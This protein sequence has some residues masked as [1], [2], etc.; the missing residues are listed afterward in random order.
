MANIPK[1]LD[2]EHGSALIKVADKTNYRAV[3]FHLVNSYSEFQDIIVFGNSVG[4]WRNKLIAKSSVQVT[5]IFGM[6][7]QALRDKDAK[8][9]RFLVIVDDEDLDEST[10]AK[11]VK[12]V[13]STYNS[14]AVFIVPVKGLL[15]EF[16]GSFNS[17]NYMATV[18][19]TTILHRLDTTDTE[20]SVI[21]VN[22]YTG[23]LNTL[24]L[25]RAKSNGLALAWLS[26][27]YSN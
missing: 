16:V 23:E 9:K 21:P 19:D 4:F 24:A 20:A 5:S 8:D 14:K 15:P 2:L 18:G 12:L 22:E 17:Y 10:L 27:R 3:M 6:L 13:D 1:V 25:L 26:S 7:K 11:V